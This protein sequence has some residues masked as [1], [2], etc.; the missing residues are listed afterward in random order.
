MYRL[1]NYLFLYFL[2]ASVIAAILMIKNSSFGAIYPED[3]TGSFIGDLAWRT[4]IG[5]L[6]SS[7][8][9]CQ[10]RSPIGNN[11]KMNYKC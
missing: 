8:N 1:T 5:N 7:Y 10:F 11:D 2:L 4:S 3:L 9:I 6:P